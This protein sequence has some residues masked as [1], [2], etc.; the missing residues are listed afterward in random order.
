MVQH[1]L[2]PKR[3]L[4]IGHRK[5]MKSSFDKIHR[6][7]RK[8]RKLLDRLSPEER[9]TYLE[10]A[11]PL[12]AIHVGKGKV[13]HSRAALV[14]SLVSRGQICVEIGTE[15][16]RWAKFL[17]ESIFPRELHIVDVDLSRL[18]H[19]FDGLENVHLWETTSKAFLEKM[20]DEYFDVI[21]IDASHAYSQV[22]VDANLSATRVKIGG[23]IIFNDYTTW[24]PIECEPYGVLR[25]VNELLHRG[26]FEIEGLSLQPFGYH[27]IAL[28][29]LA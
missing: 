2:F 8:L 28:R 13:F 17:L 22:S 16:G 23:L 11:P 5:I 14:L 9:G 19:D 20:D 4:I 24:S 25:A 10:F 7:T 27:D 18:E 1:N 3:L 26:G 29:R 15:T 12:S 21:Y 6:L